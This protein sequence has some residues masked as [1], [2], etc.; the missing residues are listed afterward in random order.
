ME[1]PVISFKV[2]HS[3]LPESYII[4]ESKR[5]R[6][7][8]V[9]DSNCK[10]VPLQLEVAKSFK[11]LI[12]MFITILPSVSS[13]ESPFKTNAAQMWV[14]VVATIIFC[15]PNRLSNAT[16]AVISGSLSTVSLVSIFLPHSI[17][18]FIYIPLAFVAIIVAYQSSRS[19]F[20]NIHDACLRLD[21]QIMDFISKFSVI[22]TWLTR[23]SSGEQ[24][25]G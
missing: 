15:L 21:Q 7:S 13:K 19:I 17:G 3:R 18:F 12:M 10:T 4:P 9:S 11:D 25:Q 1:T 6:M 14:W 23:S 24:E 5:P 8:E 22:W 2:C 20:N 16:V